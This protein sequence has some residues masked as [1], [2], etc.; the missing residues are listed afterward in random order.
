MEGLSFPSECQIE[1]YLVNLLHRMLDKNPKTRINLGETMNHEWVTKEGV[2]PPEPETGRVGRAHHGTKIGAPKVA[3]SRSEDNLQRAEAL[4]AVHH[5][6]VGNS[7]AD[8][9]GGATGEGSTRESIGGTTTR[10]HAS[11]RQGRF[12]GGGSDGADGSSPSSLVRIR[13]TPPTN[14]SRPPRSSLLSSKE[15]SPPG[16]RS[17][18]ER[19]QRPLQLDCATGR[20]GKHG[21]G[22]ANSRFGQGVASANFRTANEDK[23]EEHTEADIWSDR[24]HVIASQSILEDVVDRRLVPRR[25]RM[26]VGPESELICFCVR[27]RL[28]PPVGKVFGRRS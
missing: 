12:P 27:M 14:C 5:F 4:S 20:G 3:G 1:P 16:E 6:A 23:C 21:K 2:C 15:P 25:L 26:T 17:R 13:A 19:K 22:R 11:P 8:R 7:M 10:R 28:S 18:R 9:M 24:D